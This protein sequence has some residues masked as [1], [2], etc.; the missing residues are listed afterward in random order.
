MGS[1]LALSLVALLLPGCWASEHFRAAFTSLDKDES[2][3]IDA[4]EF[5]PIMSV[6]AANLESADEL[7]RPRDAGNDDDR[8]TTARAQISAYDLDGDPLTWSFEEFANVAS[9]P[10]R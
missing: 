5:L 8:M 4:S 7:G 1:R 10:P 9:S 2:G 3:A 6:V